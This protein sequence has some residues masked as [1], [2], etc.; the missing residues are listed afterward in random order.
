MYKNVQ[1]EMSMCFD[2]IIHF[3]TSFF[4]TT[5]TTEVDEETSTGI[6]KR[7]SAFEV[8]F[9]SYFHIRS[10]CLI[11]HHN[12]CKRKMNCYYIIV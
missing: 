5:A 2:N 8:Y 6:I 9:S 7:V 11:I 12:H 4:T 3:C 1:Q 10:L